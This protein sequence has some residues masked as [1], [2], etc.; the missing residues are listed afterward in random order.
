[1]GPCGAQLGIGVRLQPALNSPCRAFL[2][3]WIGVLN[4]I[5]PL[6][7]VAGL[8]HGLSRNESEVVALRQDPA[9]LVALHGLGGDAERALNDAD[10]FFRTEK[11]IPQRLAVASV[12]RPATVLPTANRSV[13]LSHAALTASSDTGTLLPGPNTGTYIASSGTSTGTGT[14]T[15]P[16]PAPRRTP[17]PAP[18]AAPSPGR[19]APGG[20]YPAVLPGPFPDA[21]PRPPSTVP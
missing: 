7:A 21:G 19:P 3:N 15:A 8:V 20:P 2:T 18:V 4:G 13:L 14:S 16:A 11:P 5:M 10:R 6:N 9:R 12:M 1:M 17:T